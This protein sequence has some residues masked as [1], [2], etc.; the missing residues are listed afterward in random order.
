M[1]ASGNE[2]KLFKRKIDPLASGG[3]VAATL[4]RWRGEIRDCGDIVRCG[5]R[6]IAL[7]LVEEVVLRSTG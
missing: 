7:I 6:P 2:S 3:D 5:C 4:S 1:M